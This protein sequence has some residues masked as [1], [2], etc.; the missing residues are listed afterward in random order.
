MGRGRGVGAMACTV[1]VSAGL[2]EMPA[3][4]PH[5]HERVPVDGVR[6]PP[7]TITSSSSAATFASSI[8]FTTSP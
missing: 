3:D 4:L 5:G 1:L 2:F 7:V 8:L 6:L